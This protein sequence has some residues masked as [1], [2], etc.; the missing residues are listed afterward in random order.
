MKHKVQTPRVSRDQ[1]KVGKSVSKSNLQPGDLIFSSTRS[2]GTVTHVGI[3]V[4]NS[5]M[6]HAPNSKSVVKKVDINNSYWNSVYV[7]AKRIL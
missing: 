3:Y 1:Y 2:D 4:G 7:G 6:I 5:Q